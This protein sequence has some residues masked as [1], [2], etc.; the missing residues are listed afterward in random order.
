MQVQLLEDYLRVPLFRRNGRHVELTPAAEILWPKVKQELADLER[1]I[2]ELSVA[3]NY[4]C[5][6]CVPYESD[7]YHSP[8]PCGVRSKTFHTGDSKSMPRSLISA[9][10]RGCAV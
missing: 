5:R 2:D 10:M 7:A 6:A 4:F 3:V 1:A 8:R 9:A